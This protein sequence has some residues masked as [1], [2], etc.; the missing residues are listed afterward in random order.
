MK[1][2]A[3]KTESNL[4]N[5]HHTK[6]SQTNKLI[7]N[8]TGTHAWWGFSCWNFRTARWRNTRRINWKFAWWCCR[9]TWRKLRKAIVL[10][11]ESKNKWC[12]LL[13][14]T[15]WCRALCWKHS[16]STTRT[17]RRGR[18]WLGSSY[19]SGRSTAWIPSCRHEWR[20]TRRQGLNI[21]RYYVS[22]GEISDLN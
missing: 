19:L 4:S 8:Q 11:V 7:K 15:Y 9:S 1:R 18:L 22:A 20:E 17:R 13:L 2:W 21:K 3:L 6:T 10:S 14:E 12:V 16:W 5:I